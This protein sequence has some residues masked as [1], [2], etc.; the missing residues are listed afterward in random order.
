[1]GQREGL[2]AEEVAREVAVAAVAQSGGRVPGPGFLTLTV[3][4]L[5]GC[6]PSRHHLELPVLVERGR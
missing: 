4:D 3:N 5:Q 2:R 6:A 1:M